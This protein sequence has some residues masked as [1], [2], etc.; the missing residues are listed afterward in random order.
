MKRKLKAA[1]LAFAGVLVMSLNVCAS[2]P[3]DGQVIDGSVL[4]HQGKCE[5]MELFQWDFEDTDEVAPLGAYYA[6]GTC[7]LSKQSSTSIYIVATTQCY[8]T[9]PTVKAGVTLQ[10]LKNKTWHYVGERNNTAKRA[11]T[12]TADGTLSVS[13]GYYYRV[14]STHSATKNGRTESGS[15]ISDSLYVN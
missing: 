9:C 7:A 11:N 3:V 2:E 15:A 4:T 10:Q 13:P 6:F 1:L 5:G 12:V 14:I 8:E